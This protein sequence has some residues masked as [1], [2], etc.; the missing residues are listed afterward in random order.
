M[1][2]DDISVSLTSPCPGTHSSKLCSLNSRIRNCVAIYNPKVKCKGSV[3]V[4]TNPTSPSRTLL[5]RDRGEEC[6][7]Q[8][9]NTQCLNGILEMPYSFPP[10]LFQILYKLIILQKIPCMCFHLL[11]NL[12]ARCPDLGELWCTLINSYVFLHQYY[13]SVKV[14]TSH[15]YRMRNHFPHKGSICSSELWTKERCHSH[16]QTLCRQK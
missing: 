10:T 3:H 12:E 4:T 9:Y 16:E 7:L 8:G 13:H 11:I 2:S 15:T 1:R 5:S 6:I 14:I